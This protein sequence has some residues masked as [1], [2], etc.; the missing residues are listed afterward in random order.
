MELLLKFRQKMDK[1]LK[2]APRLE[3]QEVKALWLRAKKK[4]IM[5]NQASF[6][7]QT[8]VQGLPKI[9]IS[10]EST[11]SWPSHHH[12]DLRKEDL[13]LELQWLE[14]LQLLLGDLYK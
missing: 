7:Q 5:I 8:L 10:M 12:K 13:A 4:E 2:L 1:S 3:A 11:I 14:A 6:S 9:R